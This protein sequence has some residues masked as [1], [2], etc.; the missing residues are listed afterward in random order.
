MQE[1][2]RD[3]QQSIALVMSKSK[4]NPVEIGAAATDLLRQFGLVALGFV[5]LRIA[6]AAATGLTESGPREFYAAKLATAH[7]FI[8]RQLPEARYRAAAVA[9][10]SATLMTIQVEQF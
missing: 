2:L 5:W 8:H 6:K 3:L 4:D 1:A 7:F 9:S 10:G